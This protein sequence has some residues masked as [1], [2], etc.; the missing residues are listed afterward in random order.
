MFT[1]LNLYIKSN[2][3]QYCKESA[4]ISRYGNDIARILFDKYISK[5]IFMSVRMFTL[6]QR[7][8]TR[9]ILGNNWSNNDVKFFIDLYIVSK[10]FLFYSFDQRQ[11]N[12]RA[13]NYHRF[14]NADIDADA[15]IN[16]DAEVKKNIY[17]PKDFDHL[18]TQRVLFYQ[19][20]DRK[21]IESS[22][23]VTAN[24]L[25]EIPDLSRHKLALLMLET[26]G[27]L[28]EMEYML[29]YLFELPNYITDYFDWVVIIIEKINKSIKRNALEL[30]NKLNKEFSEKMQL[31]EVR[32]SFIQLIQDIR[33]LQID[34]YL[35]NQARDKDV[36]ISIKEKVIKL[37]NLLATSADH[38]ELGLSIGPNLEDYVEFMESFEEKNKKNFPGC[39]SILV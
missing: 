3:H 35:L 4:N 19:L 8:L 6:F 2:N 16:T 33:V 11:K 21:R 24:K 25:N 37:Q 23:Y 38:F 31:S 1:L 10:S 9:M 34:T 5:F 28:S 36:I 15:D 30:T 12:I 39:P 17:V 20:E 14:C 7:K 18:F 22:Q 27:F 26:L 32:E 13:A 29:N